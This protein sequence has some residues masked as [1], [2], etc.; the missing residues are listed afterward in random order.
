MRLVVII[1]ISLLAGSAFAL[2]L[3]PR[4]LIELSDPASEHV[5]SAAAFVPDEIASLDLPGARLEP[6]FYVPR[7]AARL[8]IWLELGMNRWFRLRWNGD[9]F[10]AEAIADALPRT[11]NIHNVQLS[12]PYQ[13][14]VIP[15]DFAIYNLWGLTKMH[16]PA[17]WDIHHG[18]SGVIVTTV[19]TGCELAHPDL[20]ANVH[21]NDGE[22]LNHNG[23]WD[24]SD[25]ND[26][27]DDQNGFVDDVCGWDFVA[28]VIPEENWAQGE[29]YGPRDN[30]VYPDVH[31]HGTHI[32]GSAGAVTDNNTG[33]ASASWNVKV[34]PLRA[35]FAAVDGQQLQG[36]GYSDDFAAAYQYAAD[37]GARVIS[38]SFGGPVGVD[39]EQ[40][41]IL[42]ARA[43][44]VIVFVAA[45]NENS[46]APS[47]PAAF[48]GV[49]AVVATD[50]FDHRA[51]FSNFG[52]WVD[53]C[54][55]GVAIWSTMSNNIYHASDY[56]MWQGTSMA[57]PNAAAV[58]G[59]VLNYE[60]TLTDDE[61]EAIMLASCD[62]IDTLNPTFAGRLGAG[63]INAEAALQL[64][65][66]AEFPVPTFPEITLNFETGAYALL[67]SLSG[68]RPDFLRYHIRIDGQLA[69]STLIP[70]YGGTLPGFGYYHFAITALYEAG[71]SL[72]MPFI[73]NWPANV[74][75]P[76]ADDF[77]NTL[78]GWFLSG[79]VSLVTTPVH[80][81]THAARCFNAVALPSALQRNFSPVAAVEVS[82]WTRF[83]TLP[84]IP[85]ASHSIVG[86]WNTNGEGQGMALGTDGGLGLWN[87]PQAQTMPLDPEV[88]LAVNRWY[89]YIARQ[90]GNEFYATVLD[91]AWN[92]ISNNVVPIWNFPAIVSTWLFSA[93]ISG[94][95]YWDDAWIYEPLDRVEYFDPVPDTND[96]YALVIT[97]AGVDGVLL[98][99]GDEIAVFDGNL[100]VG[101][102]EVSGQ[103]PLVFNVWGEDET[104]AG[105]TGGNV[106]IFMLWRAS[107][108]EHTPQAFY[109]VGD[110]TFASGLCSRL[111]VWDGPTGAENP[112]TPFEFA[113]QA[114][115][116]N[117]FNPATQIRFSLPYSGVA[118]LRVYNLI[119]QRVAELVNE[120][121]EGGVHVAMFDGSTLASGV[122]LCRLQFGSSTA[123]QKMLLLK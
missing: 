71:E 54:A 85:L 25:N 86:F 46:D 3:P 8:Q 67:W 96:P 77:E 84:P 55:P 11:G 69:D 9:P 111:V 108:G 70:E 19:D 22:D 57:T 123:I 36:Q 118:T 53:L 49:L 73:I 87:Y 88:T 66:S 107:D 4:V 63:R 15:N 43:N 61:V 34:M 114:A 75:L 112:L 59:L 2:E 97:S 101:A 109:D 5:R 45:G 17:A 110:G 82:V 1:A 83:T 58:A 26:L 7:D 44:N 105:F 29:E 65:Q 32:M 10:E 81:G 40:A 90:Q 28:A 24:E 27:D 106:M 113:L 92:V 120:S 18:N 116:P 48:D 74:G 78:D 13:A 37:N 60:P 35:G 16:C 38:V 33:V 80:S 119:G 21:V 41:G 102:A 39:A 94:S 104:G 72:P 76:F 115:Y 31:G 51:S 99:P 91:S 52:D 117:P 89:H 103:W 93:F 100:C 98:E 68:E 47:Y 50:S 121:L 23:V 79:D 20:A 30:L 62:N 12:F 95:G 56:A 64:V 42:Y 6:I 122:Y 14:S